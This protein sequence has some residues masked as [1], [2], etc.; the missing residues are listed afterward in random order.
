MKLKGHKINGGKAEGE[1]VVINTGFSFVGDLD[2][3][4]GR[5]TNK[6]HE[7]EGQSLAN[8]ILVFTSGKGSSGGPFFAYAAKKH[9]IAPAAMICLEAEPI[10]GLAA[11]T[12]DIPM[13]DKL[14]R[15]PLKLIETGDHLKIDADKGVVEITKA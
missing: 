1:A 10:I 5:F 4:T 11:I 2:I 9:K 7:L 6:G 8:K 12:A 14:N 13:I 3:A 15:N